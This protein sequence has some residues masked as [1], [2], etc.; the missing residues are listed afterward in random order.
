[1]N[2]EEMIIAR[3]ERL[4]RQIMP[5][6]ETARA[7]GELRAELAPRVNEAVHALIL[8]LADVEAD[9]QLEDLLFFV[10]KVLR[11][12]KN[13]NFTLDQ[14]K[15]VIDFAVNVEPLLKSTVPQLILY[16]DNLERS[17]VFRML[18]TGIDVLKKIGS[19][20]SPEELAQAGAGMVRLAEAFKK[21]SE[22]QAV[23]FFERAVALPAK[24]DL[25]G[26]KATGPIGLLW[27]L[28]GNEARE[29]LGV[30]VALT[31]GL[32]ALRVEAEAAA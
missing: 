7:V 22:P 29:G 28:G 5:M 9:F 27:A 26:A 17:G 19:N 15:N 8:E 20:Y 30:L 2:Y 3:L 12:L 21:L 4:E 1:M 6:A 10:K 11:N 24:I 23:D 16:L 14:L 25:A 32:S 31:K 13:L 18:N